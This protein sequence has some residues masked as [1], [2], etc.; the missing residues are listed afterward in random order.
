MPFLHEVLDYE[1]PADSYGPMLEHNRG[2]IREGFAALA[3]APPG[4]VV[5][6]CHGGRDRTGVLVALAL[7]VAGVP[8]DAV[9]DDYALTDGTDRVA[10]E[11]TLRHLGDAATYLLDAGVSTAQLDAVRTR[12]VSS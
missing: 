12:L 2:P 1:V 7:C 9:A 10:M 3:D 6:H 11:N 8:A 5:V 4:G